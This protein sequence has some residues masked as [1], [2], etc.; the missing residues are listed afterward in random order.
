MELV[1]GDSIYGYVVLHGDLA[2]LASDPDG[3]EVI[4]SGDGAPFHTAIEAAVCAKV[5]CSEAFQI[6]AVRTSDRS[7]R[8]S[9]VSR[10]S[11]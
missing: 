10:R 4:V 5:T 2:N 8:P 1:K 6:V 11:A 3:V 7:A 9:V